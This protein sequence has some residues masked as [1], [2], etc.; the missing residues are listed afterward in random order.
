M[1][2]SFV[3]AFWLAIGVAAPIAAVA[4]TPP[5]LEDGTLRLVIS[6]A[7]GGINDTEARLLARYLSPHLPGAPLIV[8]Q[9]LPGASGA[10]M[11][12]FLL[13]LDPIAEPT[14]AMMASAIPFRSRAGRL[15]GIFDARTANWIGS[16]AASTTVCLAGT[17][18]GVASV[19]DLP[20]R[21]L[22]FGVLNAGSSM[23]AFTT[24]FNNVLGFAIDAVAGYDSIG[25][26]ALA[27]QR[28]EL[29][30]LCAPYSSYPAI[31]QPMV[32]DG[33]ARL[34]LYIDTVPRPEFDV[35]WLFDLAMTP[36]QRTF[37][38]AAV[39]STSIARPFAMPVGTD[40][41]L[42]E[43]MRAAFAAAV[44]DPAFLAEAA[45]LGIDVRPRTGDEIAAAVA[46]LY[47]MPDALVA[48]INA[49]FF[50]E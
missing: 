7:A 22:K 43:T 40:P 30:G 31:L 45:G 33:T 24:M 34:L 14:I 48:E 20:G 3:R 50:A 47:A 11:L 37:L 36:D 26:I 2:R 29:D 5:A 44:A 23:G 18:S 17:A 39:T 28:G 35:P 4:Q 38:E 46:A 27:V 25:A 32:E 8:A 41:A 49:L 42:V 12:E 19:A 6:Q 13:Q 9:N 1:I 16:F 15:D 10:R 21:S